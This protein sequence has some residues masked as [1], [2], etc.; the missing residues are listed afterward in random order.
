MRLTTVSLKGGYR[1]LP[2]LGLLAWMGLILFLSSRS[3]LPADSP[4]VRWLGQYQDE[5]GHLGEYAVLGMLAYMALRP[6]LS[7]GR[8]F[9]VGL[10]FSMVFALGDEAF[11]GL[12]PNRAPEFKDIVLDAV[13]ASSSLVAVG[14][15]GSR[16]KGYWPKRVPEEGETRP[17]RASSWRSRGPGRQR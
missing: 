15:L 17:G 11:Q 6:F 8:T 10:A 13:G 4:T 2:A 16:L 14:V 9:V 7:E 5:V 12:I 3:S 1:L